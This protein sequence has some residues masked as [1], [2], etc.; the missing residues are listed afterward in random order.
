MSTVIIGVGNPVLTDDGVGIHV[1]EMIRAVLPAA[2]G[3]TVRAS[4]LGGLRLVDAMIGF[5]RA[6]I[7]DALS[8]GTN[9]PGTVVH[10]AAD[11][12]R[13]GRN[14]ASVDDLDLPTALEFATS[15]GVKVPE[16]VEAWGIEIADATSFSEY[17]SPAVRAA[18]PHIVAEIC[19]SAQQHTEPLHHDVAG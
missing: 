2:Q 10:L 6:I 18:V 12:L 1:A 17:M 16:Q 8:T 5:D 11:K 9:P 19:R 13:Q 15:A 3:I 4:F 7:V 14:S